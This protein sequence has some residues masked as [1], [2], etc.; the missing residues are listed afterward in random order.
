MIISSIK[1]STVLNDLG[2]KVWNPQ[3]K[4]SKKYSVFVELISDTGLSGVGE[5]W[6]F[7]SSPDALIAFLRTE[8]LPH[9]VGCELNE[10]WGNLG[11]LKCRAVLTA[12]HGILC[13]A[14]SGVD[15]GL[16]DLNAKSKNVPLWKAINADG[17]GVAHLYASGGLYGSNKTIELLCKEMKSYIDAGFDT[18]KMKIGGMKI[19]DDIAR[20]E[21]VCRSIGPNVSLIIDGVYSYDQ[22]S[23]LAIFS[24]VQHNNI[25]AFQSPMRAH[26]FSHMRNLCAQDVPVMMTEAEYRPEVFEQLIEG[27]SVKILQV[28][29]IACGGITPLLELAERASK[30]GVMLSPE[31]S[32]TAVAMMAGC[33]LAAA[34]ES[35]NLVEY[36]MVH[37]VFF[38]QLPFSSND[39][40]GSKV[41]LPD[42][43][44]LGISLVSDNVMEEF[45]LNQAKN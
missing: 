22:E 1:V 27:G 28:S 15:I 30:V 5:C 39:L 20:I 37:Q 33:H 42:S 23:A 24:K 29:P 14:S 36:H 26:N 35:I 45:C 13:S 32:S 34:F 12:R 10:A 44:G 7:D 31:I 8:V 16:W 19:D 21:A 17:A 43:A 2:G 38:D 18:V 11:D 4:W 6:C 25:I 40:K 9:I 41:P 3:I